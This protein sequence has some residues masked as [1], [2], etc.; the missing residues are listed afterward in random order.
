MSCK[1]AIK[2]TRSINTD[3]DTLGMEGNVIERRQSIVTPTWT[4]AK[5][6]PSPAGIFVTP[7]AVVTTPDQ[8]H[9][10]RLEKMQEFDADDATSKIQ[11]K[12]RYEGK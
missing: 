1:G 11:I 3:S 5:P 9:R 7:P 4:E 10:H 8:D 12:D 2:K 6:P